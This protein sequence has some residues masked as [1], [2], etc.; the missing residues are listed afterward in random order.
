MY[1]K[2]YKHGDLSGERK[3]NPYR[4]YVCEDDDK[5]HRIKLKLV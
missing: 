5:K 1:V 2:G 3:I 4:R